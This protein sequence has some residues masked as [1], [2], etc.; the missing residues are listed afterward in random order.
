MTRLEKLEL[1]VK[2]GFIYYPNTGIITNPNGTIAKNLT[3]NGYV[4][5]SLW[6]EGKRYS[7]T[8]HQFAWFIIYNEVVNLIDHKNRIKTDNSK[9]NLR[10]VTKSQNAMNMQNTK[11]YCLCKRCNKFEAYINLNGKKK[12]LGYFILESDASNAYQRAKKIY[13]IIN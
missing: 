3:A 6:Y 1:A 11:G 2:K 9:D 10:S 7:L 8:G 13:H 12:Y 4:K 5:L